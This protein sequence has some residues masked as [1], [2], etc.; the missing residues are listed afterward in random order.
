[1]CATIALASEVLY[2][3]KGIIEGCTIEPFG[4]PFGTFH[5]QVE[6]LNMRRARGRDYAFLIS[7]EGLE[8][9]VVEKA[10]QSSFLDMDHSES[11]F[12]VI[13][14][15]KATFV[16]NPIV[17]RVRFADHDEYYT[18][19]GRDDLSPIE[20][21]AVWFRKSE[22]RRMRKEHEAGARN[23]TVEVDSEEEPPKND[24]LQEALHQ[25]MAVSVVLEE[26]K[27]QREQSLS[28]PDLISEKYQTFVQRSR[29]S[30]FISNLVR[31]E[32]KK[33]VRRPL[34][35][36]SDAPVLADVDSLR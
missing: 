18:V 17:G 13:F 33:L 10:A 24:D 2:D 19:Q 26:Q 28:D 9:E 32:E 11:S 8:V 16:D 1:M 31:E 14:N 27:R 35:I 6:A 21:K 4:I 7:P 5:P 30:M 34:R 3:Q 15:G 20:R 12:E 22:L 29:L 23:R 25:L 36:I